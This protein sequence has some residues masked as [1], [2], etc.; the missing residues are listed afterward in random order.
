MSVAPH[1]TRTGPPDD[2]GAQRADA[3]VPAETAP[4][5]TAPADPPPAARPPHPRRRA[6]RFSPLTLKILFVN[7][8]ALVVLAIG[9]L[10]VDDYRRGL[11][12]S[13]LAAMTIEA[14]LIATGIGA[15]A[16]VSVDTDTGPEERLSPDL[17]RPVLRRLM[18][19]APERARLYA[20][21]T[22]LIAD[23]R[24]LSA[25][26]GAVEVQPLP[27][28]GASPTWLEDAANDAYDWIVSW[29]PRERLTPFIEL[30]IPL[31]TDYVETEAALAGDTMAVLRDAD[32]VG[33][34]QI[35]SV[36]VPV[37]RYREV[38][39]VL[40]L[41]ADSTEI[42]QSIR[43]VRFSIFKAFAAALAITVLLSIYLAGTIARPI[44][45]LARAAERVRTR[46]AIGASRALGGDGTAPAIPDMTRRHDEIGDLSGAL[47]EMTQ[48][49]WRR[50]NAI[51]SFAA[52]V[53][54]EIKNPLTSLKSAVETA[55]LVKDPAQ[56][57]RLMQIMLDD[58][59][60]I[61]RLIGDI[62]S[63]SRLDAELSR[64]HAAPVDVLVLLRALVDL[65]EAT[66]KPEHP[67]IAL[68]VVGAGPFVVPGIEDRLGQVFRNV[69]VNGISF[70][71]PDGLLRLVIARTD[72]QVEVMVEDDGPGIPAGKQDAIFDRFY[73][74]RP[75]TEKFGMHS[76]LGL[77][78]S[79]QIIEAHGGTITAENRLDETGA[80]HGARFIVSLPAG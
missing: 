22:E 19:S 33:S 1:V 34:M 41:I 52:D 53:A 29:L 27:P 39:G 68:D 74:E 21:T 49:L 42:D 2:D 78:I 6:R 75:K 45:R 77:S 30:P 15:A 10:Y 72:G 37:Q 18:E 40:Q 46:G 59:Q 5:E 48:A 14:R 57:Q 71:P 26:G 13:R 60:R 80:V 12:E 9:F 36:A 58:V 43:Q 17:A 56:R 63:A 7:V 62:S 51:E 38:L 8:F 20:T 28:P 70:S 31:V 11:I 23:S 47:I 66:R 67:R 24:V 73:S 35:L 64:G 32:L 79:R 61:D 65:Q 54:H 76:G 4:G 50:V 55:S 69:V 16:T 3:P 44:R 25:V